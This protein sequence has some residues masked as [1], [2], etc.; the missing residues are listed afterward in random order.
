[1][2][3]E[4]LLAFKKLGESENWESGKK[5]SQATPLERKDGT[6]GISIKLGKKVDYSTRPV[7][8]KTIW[9][10][11]E[12]DLPSWLGWFIKTIKKMYFKIFSKEIKTA[13]EQIEYY[14][15]QTES[16]TQKLADAQ[17]NLEEAQAK[18]E[19]NK[20]NQQYA[21][22]VKDKFDSFQKILVEFETLVTESLANQSGKEED[23]KAK[24]KENSW[25]LGLECSV[26][27]KNQDVDNQTEI[28]LHV[29]T[30][31]DQDRIFELKSPNL[32]PFVRTKKESKTRLL[33]SS[34]LS[35][36]L[37]ELIL[38]LERTNVYAHLSSEGTYP[39][40]KPSGYLLMGWRLDQEEKR[41]MK[42][43]NFHLYPHV[44]IFTYDE[45]LENVKNELNLIKMVSDVKP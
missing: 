16:L 10:D 40:T 33:M 43:L 11:E 34:E 32:K 30:K 3:K 9:I 5:V 45:L 20:I 15:A 42:Y 37:S 12:L 2:K 23:I 18:D 26:E 25:L 8:S 39:I 35:N 13:D 28:D 27:A 24:I 19:E 6:K 1:M 21:I 38:Y 14:K 22:Q 31:F 17:K 41:F 44:Q 36:G 29:K 7:Y 4:K